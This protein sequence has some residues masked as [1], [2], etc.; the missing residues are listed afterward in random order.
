LASSST[1]TVLVVDSDPKAR[2]LLSKL[3]QRVGYL[4]R[5]ESAGDQALE[6]VGREQPEVAILDVS[7]P[8]I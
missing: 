4:V 5:E 1:R 7:L 8:G 3:F 2:E 6:Q